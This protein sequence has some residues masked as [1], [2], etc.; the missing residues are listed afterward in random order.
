MG[1][2]GKAPSPDHDETI[3]AFDRERAEVHELTRRH[4]EIVAR[5]RSNDRPVNRDDHHQDR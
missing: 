1:N 3:A 2:P 4:E 5:L